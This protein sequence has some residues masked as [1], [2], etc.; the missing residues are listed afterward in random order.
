M[1]GSSQVAAPSHPNLHR[2]PCHVFIEVRDMACK[3]R[4]HWNGTMSRVV[5]PQA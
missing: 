4:Q 5:T 2:R 3:M 1:T